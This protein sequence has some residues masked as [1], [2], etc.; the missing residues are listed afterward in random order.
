MIAWEMSVFNGCRHTEI[1]NHVLEGKKLIKRFKLQQRVKKNH[2]RYSLWHRL[3]ET[4]KKHSM[5]ASNTSSL[6]LCLCLMSFIANNFI[7][8]I[9]IGKNNENSQG[10]FP[11]HLSQRYWSEIRFG[12]R[13]WRARQHPPTV[14]SQEH[15]PPPI[16]QLIIN[17]SIQF[18]NKKSWRSTALHLPNRY[19]SEIGLGSVFEE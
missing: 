15:P 1:C 12:V 10:S 17:D 5:L 11:L 2:R 9:T 4:M 19:W 13:I 14:K 18:A 7:V 8:F 16:F 6:N 3:K